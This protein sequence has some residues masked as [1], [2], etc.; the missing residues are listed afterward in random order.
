MLMEHLLTNLS[1]MDTNNFS[2]HV[3][4]GEREG[5]VFS[6]MVQRRHFYMTHGIGRSGDITADQ[7]KA[8]GS[9]LLYKLCNVLALDALR[10]G[11]TPSVEKGGRRAH[12][13]RHVHSAGLADDSTA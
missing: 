3:G 5:R 2:A 8:A 1:L 7:P 4:A 13:N 10:V 12:G 9:T 6:T 11:G